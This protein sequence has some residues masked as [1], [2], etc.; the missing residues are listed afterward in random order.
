MF[1]VTSKAFVR[2][3]ALHASPRLSKQVDDLL[4]REVDEWP[5]RFAC[6]LVDLA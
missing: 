4:T 5:V 2:D 1:C 3:A 6:T